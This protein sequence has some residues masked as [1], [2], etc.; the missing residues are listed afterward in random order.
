MDKV[1][2]ALSIPLKRIADLL[3]AG[4]EGGINYWA[5]I[6]ARVQTPEA[7]NFLFEEGRVYVSELPL[8]PG[9]SVQLGVNGD[10]TASQPKCKPL[11]LETV[12]QGL[13]IMA[14]EYPRH[15]ADF[16][17]GGDDAETGDV[18]I[19]CCVFGELIFG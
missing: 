3:C 19:Q 18:F 11:N 1:T 6:G 17:G 14:K 15:F 16:L 12:E 13:A 4:F 10:T 2:V 7:R 9:C 8:S 5:V